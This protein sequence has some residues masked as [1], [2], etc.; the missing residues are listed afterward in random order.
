MAARDEFGAV[1]IKGTALGLIA[2]GE[3]WTSL[4][5]SIDNSTDLA[6]APR[7]LYAHVAGNV[8][9]V[10]RTGSSASFTF[11]AGEIKSVRPYRIM[12]TG[13][14]TAFLASGALIGIY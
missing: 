6:V 4:H 9:C 12:S 14:S 10:S 13:T 2:P 8:Q 3:D 11:A 7:A 5:A 1:G